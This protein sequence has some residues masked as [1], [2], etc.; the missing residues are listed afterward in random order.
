MKVTNFT[1]RSATKDNSIALP[2]IAMDV[3]LLKKFLVNQIQRF[4]KIVMYHGELFPRI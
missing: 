1:P 3:K 4:V 2:P